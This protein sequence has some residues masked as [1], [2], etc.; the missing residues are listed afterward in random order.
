MNSMWA[1]RDLYNMLGRGAEERA[2]AAV[3]KLDESVNWMTPGIYISLVLEIHMHQI[4]KVN[5]F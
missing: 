5:T 3:L 1:Q 2:D 4:R